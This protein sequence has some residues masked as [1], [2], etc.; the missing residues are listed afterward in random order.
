[1]LLQMVVQSVPQTSSLS[2]KNGGHHVQQTNAERD[3][4]DLL[5][6]TISL[7]RLLRYIHV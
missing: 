6:A 3:L 1:M 2:G 5:Y 7:I 4:D